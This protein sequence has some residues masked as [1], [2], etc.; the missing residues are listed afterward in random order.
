MRRPATARTGS[1]AV[2]RTTLAFEDVLGWLVR[3]QATEDY[4]ID[5]QVEIDDGGVVEGRLLAVQVKGGE[6]WFNK[7]GPGGWWYRPSV[8]HVRYWRNHSLPVVVVLHDPRTKVCY[9][10]LINEKTLVETSGGGWKLLVPE[11]Q[12]LDESAR[13]PLRS[14]ADGDPY[15]LRIRSLRLAR[16][17][18]DLLAD[19]TRLIV[20]ADEWINK[21]SGRGEISLGVDNEDGE[22]PTHLAT[23]TVLLG[24]E[25]YAEAIPRLFPWADA[26]LHAETYDDADYDDWQSECVLY[27]EGDRIEREPYADWHRRIPPGLRPYGNSDGEVDH[28]RLELTLN[29]LGRSFRTVDRYATEGA[30]ILTP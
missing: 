4:G 6:S 7:P 20:D 17:W 12:V 1:V 19:G 27:D 10:Q 14:A 26:S 30:E 9:W 28:W 23:W 16:P 3:E 2:T 11:D 29:D 18:M 15:E 5:L 22:D 25:P 24:F 13:Q 21:S 8:D